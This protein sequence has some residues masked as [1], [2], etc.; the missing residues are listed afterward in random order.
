MTPLLE[1]ALMIEISCIGKQ[2]LQ[3]HMALDVAGLGCEDDLVHLMNYV[4]TN[5]F[6]TSPHVVNAVMETIEG[7]PNLLEVPNH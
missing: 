3:K 4:W 5:I 2:Q 1:D 6:E 7:I